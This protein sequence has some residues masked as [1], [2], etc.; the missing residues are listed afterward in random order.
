MPALQASYREDDM[1]MVQVKCLSPP[2][3]IAD[4]P[5]II[6]II[7]LTMTFKLKKKMLWNK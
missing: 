2:V 3:S 4:A 5:L 1:G 6:A 7:M